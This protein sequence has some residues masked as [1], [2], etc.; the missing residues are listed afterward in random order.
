[1]ESLL[2]FLVK[3]GVLGFAL[4]TVETWHVRANTLIEDGIDAFSDDQG[5]I[6]SLGD[7]LEQGSHLLGALKVV[8]GTI[9]F[10]PVGLGLAGT[11]R[12]AQ[13]GVVGIG[14]LGMHV[15]EVVGGHQR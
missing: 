9:E 4:W 3:P 7:V 1:M 15:V 6:T 13:Q 8:A 2:H 5:I 14:V 12:N 10:E 11:G